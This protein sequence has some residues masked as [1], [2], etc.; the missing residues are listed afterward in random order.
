MKISSPREQKKFDALFSDLIGVC[1]DAA[2]KQIEAAQTE[3]KAAKARKALKYY[4]R[5]MD[6]DAVGL[7]VFKQQQAE[8]DA[9]IG[10]FHRK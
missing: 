5:Y 10:K 8:L 6:G 4:E 3:I 9:L 7:G 1:R 2:N